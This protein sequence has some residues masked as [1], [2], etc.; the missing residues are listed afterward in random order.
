MVIYLFM[1]KIRLIEN[2]INKM[3]SLIS[4]DLGQTISEQEEKYGNCGGSN[5]ISLP[6]ISQLKIV[7]DPKTQKPTGVKFKFSAYFGAANTEDVYTQALGLVKKGIM[8]ELE[9]KNLT[10]L[11]DMSLIGLF[12]VVGSASNY[13]S[14]P[15][16]PTYQNNGSPIEAELFTQPPLDALLKKGDA[17]WDKNLGYAESRW[18]GLVNTIN[19][20]GKELGF[21]VRDGIQPKKITAKITD[22]GGCTDEKRDA[23]K[24]PKPGQYVTISGYMKLVPRPLT[25]SEKEKLFNCAKGL[26]VI[27]GFFAPKEGGR[28]ISRIEIPANSGPH[29]CDYATFDIKCNGIPV[30]VANMNNGSQYFAKNP[31]ATVG[32]D[33][34]DNPNLVERISPSG[35]GGSAINVLGVNDDLLKQM[36]EKSPNGLLNLTIQGKKGTLVRELYHGDAP[37]VCAYTVDDKGKLINQIYGPKEP[38]GAS[39]GDVGG[40]VRRLVKFNPCTKKSV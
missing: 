24:Y 36:I 21:S 12:E 5:K 29:A 28:V 3:K 20:K 38:F 23:S 1:M 40:G 7:S 10:G 11:Y 4:Y 2:E 35:R 16:Q 15:L 18:E 39:K 19:Q 31:K 8:T 34:S 13:L 9:N 25:V 30:G 33:K 6:K 22:T 14:V 26:R 32:T 27:V 17:E 37:M